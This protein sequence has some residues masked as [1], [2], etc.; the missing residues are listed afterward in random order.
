MEE[1]NVGIFGKLFGQKEKTEKSQSDTT[2]EVI[3]VKTDGSI[4]TSEMPTDN[5][6]RMADAYTHALKGII[7][8]KEGK[9]NEAIEKHK[10]SIAISLENDPNRAIY[11]TNLGVCYAQTGKIDVALEQLETAVRLDP[12]YKRARDNLEAVR[13]LK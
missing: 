10:K 12:S 6:K 5:A 2:T 8:E 4:V 3:V 1:Y 11:F 9:W 7:L 13:D